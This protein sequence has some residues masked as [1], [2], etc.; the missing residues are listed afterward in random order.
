[1]TFE[2]NSFEMIRCAIQV[3]RIL[4]PGLREKPYENALVIE[5]RRKGFN[6]TPQKA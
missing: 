2:D 1:M 4:G 6:A 5:L 3:H